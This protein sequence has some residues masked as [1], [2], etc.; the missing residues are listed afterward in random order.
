MGQVT[1]ISWTRSTRNAWSGCTKVGPGCD[2]CYA[3]AFQRWIRGKNPLTGE[4]TNWGPG[5]PRI[6]H[7]EGFVKD[8]RKW[9]RIAAWERD[10]ANGII[11]PSEKG[12]WNKPGF[13]PVFI[14]SHSD[15]FDVDAPDEWRDVVFQTIE[16]CPNLILQLVTK[17][18]GNVAKMVPAHWI[19]DGFPPNVWL[20]MTVVTQAELDRDFAKLLALKGVRVRGLS[21]EPLI[22]KVNLDSWLKMARHM[23]DEIW[24]IIGGESD[25]AGHETRAF[26]PNWALSAVAQLHAHGYAAF[27]KQLGSQPQEIA[28][29]KEVS[30]EEEKRWWANGWTKISIADDSQPPHWRRYLKLKDD[31]GADPAEWPPALRYQEFP[32]LAL[33]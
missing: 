7:L 19:T 16:A 10:H 30:K 2:G 15:T 22:E 23:G 21:L 20:I 1:G 13:Y 26:D 6:P 3:E 9:D 8:L 31:H 28:Y 27:V 18:I 5:A 25:Q 32:R 29:P 17:R 33:R 14:N 11:H 4:A 12:S 24:G